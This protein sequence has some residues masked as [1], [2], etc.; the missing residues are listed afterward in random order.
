MASDI[1][2]EKNMKKTLFYVAGAVFLG[3][4]TMLLPLRV[5]LAAYGEEGPLM[6]HP[7]YVKTLA[8]WER[9]DSLIPERYDHRVV[10]ESADPFV[11]ILGVS[12]VSALVVYVIFKRRRPYPSYR[13][14]QFFHS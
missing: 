14:H 13:Y 9:G 12:F 3:A 6:F 7:P 2:G 11:A 1:N 5:F 10:H 4:V 8:A